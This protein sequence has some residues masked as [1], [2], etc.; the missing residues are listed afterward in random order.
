MSDQQDDQRPHE[1][2]GEPAG[3]SAPI[4]DW[5][6][7]G[8]RMWLVLRVLAVLVV[9]AWLALGI[10]LGD[11]LRLALLG[12]LAGIA[13][14]VAFVAEVVVVGG[15]A[16]RGMLVAGSRGERL[17]GRDVSLVPPQLMRR[18]RR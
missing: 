9:L 8:R 7:T 18:R 5:R 6:R 17:A 14:L 16:L 1:P 13:L 10:A 4:V 12:E 11:G 3:A 2:G 15:S